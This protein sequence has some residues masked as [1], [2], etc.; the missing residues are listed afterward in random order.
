MATR[1]QKDAP[2]SKHKYLHYTRMNRDNP[3]VWFDA[4]TI[5]DAGDARAA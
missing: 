3:T 4:E 5:K 1:E 2:P